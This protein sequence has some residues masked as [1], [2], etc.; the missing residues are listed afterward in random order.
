MITD[1]L[2]AF[3]DQKTLTTTADSDIIEFPKG[4]DEIDRTLNLVAQL[5]DCAGV[6]PTSA[7]I[8]VTLKAADNGSASAWDT[9]MTFPAVSVA[10]CIAGKRLVNFAKLPLG[11]AKY[12]AFKL[13]VTVSNGPLTGAKY[14]A[15]LTPSVEA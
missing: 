13:A 1:K 11:M 4:G 2:L 10:E 9:V 6:T 5:D 8:S 14:S 12:A 15:W 7:T 3:A